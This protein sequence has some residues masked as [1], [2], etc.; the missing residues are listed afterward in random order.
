MLLEYWEQYTYFV[1]Y[2]VNLYN[3]ITKDIWHFL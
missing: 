2:A 3:V 1:S